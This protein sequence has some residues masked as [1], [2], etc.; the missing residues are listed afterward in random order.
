MPARQQTPLPTA[1]SLVKRRLQAP[2][3]T[4]EAADI[5]HLHVQELK[6]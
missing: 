1:V 6:T 3:K 2:C 4:A 5:A